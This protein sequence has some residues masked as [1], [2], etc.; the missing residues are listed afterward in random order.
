MLLERF[1]TVDICHVLQV[2][3]IPHMKTSQPPL[4]QAATHTQGA[5]GRQTLQGLGQAISSQLQATLNLQTLNFCLIQTPVSPMYTPLTT[6]RH[7]LQRK[8]QS[9][10][11]MPVGS[12]LYLSPRQ[13]LPQQSEHQQQ[14][15]QQQWER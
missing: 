12:L 8:G 10:R 7:D 14:R 5:R 9:A 11:L 6:S 4:L 15:Q 13:L 1:N 2:V 3:L